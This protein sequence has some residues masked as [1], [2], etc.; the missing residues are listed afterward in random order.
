MS[1]SPIDSDSQYFAQTALYAVGLVEEFDRTGGAN[2]LNLKAQIEQV[3]QLTTGYEV[4]LSNW[5]GGQYRIEF[6]EIV[7]PDAKD[8][9]LWSKICDRRPVLRQSVTAAFFDFLALVA[10]HRQRVNRQRVN[11]RRKPGRRAS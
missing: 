3:L 8:R 10:E 1:V 2:Y 4:E 7:A 6:A 9:W 11:R 5:Y